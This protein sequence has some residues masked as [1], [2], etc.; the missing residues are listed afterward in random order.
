MEYQMIIKMS[1]LFK[2]S[3]I[4][5]LKFLHLRQNMAL[6]MVRFDSHTIPNP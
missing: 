1:W 2:I 6:L 4:F 3:K 5:T